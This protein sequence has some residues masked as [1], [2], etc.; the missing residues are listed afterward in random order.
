MT[1]RATRMTIR[2]KPS[3][4]FQGVQKNGGK[5]PDLSGLSQCAKRMFHKRPVKNIALTTFRLQDCGSG[6]LSRI[7]INRKYAGFVRARRPQLSAG[8]EGAGIL[9]AKP[10]SFCAF[11]LPGAHP[12]IG[13]SLILEPHAR[14]W[15]L[16]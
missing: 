2:A 13:S 15:A 11:D 16:L 10:L 3:G 7:L 9:S 8:C 6:R 1:N 5:Q 14:S 12:V 4:A